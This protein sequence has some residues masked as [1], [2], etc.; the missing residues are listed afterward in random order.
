MSIKERQ[1]VFLALPLV[2]SI[3]QGIDHFRNINSHFQ[4]PEL[5][6]IPSSNLH[7]TIFYLGPVLLRDI[8]NI[9]EQV[10]AVL[11][12][13]PCLEFVF[14]NFSLQPTN[15]PRMIWA[16]FCLNQNF[17]KLVHSIADV[18]QPYLLE[19]SK[20][21]V[22]PIPHVTIARMRR[23]VKLVNLKMDMM[24][25]SFVAQKAELWLSESGVKGVVYT[26][27]ANFSFAKSDF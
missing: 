23:S 6:W 16:Q 26:P 14:Q 25:P 17:T 5:R 7:M 18:C 15:K 27:L 11:A 9:S 19:R 22:Q 3:Q 4:Q 20:H 21:H 2:K 12:V 10:R 1:R 8:G 13:K 24:L